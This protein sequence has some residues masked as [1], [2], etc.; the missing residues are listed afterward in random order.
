MKAF[1]KGVNLFVF[2]FNEVWKVD[3]KYFLFN[4]I[5]LMVIPFQLNASIYLGSKLIN[6]LS[7][8][9]FMLFDVARLLIM[10]ISMELAITI[11]SQIQIKYNLFFSERFS[12]RQK[13]RLL[14][15]FYSIN[16]VEKENPSFHGKA[17][18]Y[19][20]ALSKI[21]SNYQSFLTLISVIISIIL[22]MF[23]IRELN[24]IAIIF[25]I[26]ICI[27]RGVLELK[28]IRNRVE[29]TNVLQT[30]H[31]THGYLF[32]L[33]SDFT[34]HKEM[35]INQA[36]DF[37]KMLWL[38]KKRDAFQLQ[39]NIERKTIN[40]ITI[41][42]TISALYKL[43]LSLLCIY[44]I[45]K[46]NL[47]I[48]D[49]M[50]ITMAVPLIESNVLSLF[51]LGGNF[52]ENISYLKLADEMLSTKSNDG[53]PSSGELI[54]EIQSI[55]VRNLS[56]RYP[57]RETNA[58]NH[59]NLSINKGEKIAIVGDNASGKTTLI[60]LI[61]G[62]YQSQSN[63]IFYNGKDIDDINLLSAWKKIS[64]VFQDFTKYEL[65]IR[66]N[67]AISD[68]SEINNDDKL[69]EVINL[70]GIS[71]ILN[72]KKGLATELGY[73]TEDSINLSGGQWQRIALARTLFKNASLVV[74]DEPTSAID[75]N[76]ELDLLKNL[77]EVS[78]EKTLIVITHRIGIA[79]N[80]DKIVVMK[81]G[82]I[83]E[84]GSHVELVNSRGYYFDM[85]T[86]QKEL[87][88]RKELEVV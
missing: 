43:A 51:N 58:L 61:L 71:N 34:V 79:A 14:D 25:L 10:M 45:Y 38:K 17:N 13:T 52:Y 20:F 37:F 62:I 19:E 56:F 15:Y 33:L 63:S 16:M 86:K 35:M 12:I 67:I 18:Y 87:Y 7:S 84:I 88:N 70:F 27:V 55:E 76:S 11:F 47:T 26:I 2:S 54:T 3:K 28:T 44:N 77:I 69:N 49:Y 23:L 60:K 1:H 85:W 80:V 48:G 74:L 42:K 73:L 29:V 30:S 9:D 31:R 82:E 72:S 66:H 4:L 36:F 40:Y 81:E 21:E 59:I 83:I 8:S 24:I 22:S 46:G 53:E 75:P 50:A 68:L 5:L 78:D 6:D 32:Q 39:Y 64:V 57:N 65:D 41:S